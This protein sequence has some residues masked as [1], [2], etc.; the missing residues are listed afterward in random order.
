MKLLFD[1][2]FHTDDD[3][4]FRELEFDKNARMYEKAKIDY[5]YDDTGCERIYIKLN[6]EGDENACR[7]A[8]RDLLEDLMC[9][10][11]TFKYYLVKDL[12]DLFD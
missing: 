2:E 3:F 9:S 4:G 6:A 7:W 1:A 5:M 11:D 12:Y 8:L 10:I